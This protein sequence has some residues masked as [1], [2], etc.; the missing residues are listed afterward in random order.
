M[1]N[2][3]S[4]LPPGHSLFVSGD[5][6]PPTA[7]TAT[8]GEDLATT[9]RADALAEAVRAEPAGVVGLESAL[10]DGGSRKRSGS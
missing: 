6:K 2:A 8:I 4:A 10:H 9:L 3:R 1:G 5:R 7:L